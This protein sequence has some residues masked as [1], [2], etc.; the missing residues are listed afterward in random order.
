M[1]EMMTEAKIEKIKASSAEI[2]VRGTKEKP[3]YEI[4]YFD[5]SDNEW[6]IGYG[7]YKLEFVFAWKEVCFEIVDD[8]SK[9]KKYI[10]DLISRK[11]VLKMLYD[12]KDNSDT[13][14]NYGTILDIIRNV[15]NIPTAY[16]VDAVCDELEKFTNGECTLHECGVRSERCN[17]C[18]AGK[19]IEIVRNWGK[20]YM[21][22]N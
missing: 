21:E 13:P 19:A 16:D 14:K 8:E 18:M 7:S 12:I 2:I 6:K 9:H 15:R 10:N 4:K 1:C 20:K 11:A 17:A 3:Y 22:K 5:L